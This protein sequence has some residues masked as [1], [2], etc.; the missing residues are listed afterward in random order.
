MSTVDIAALGTLRP[1]QPLDLT[2]YPAPTVKADKPKFVMAP[3]GVYELALPTTLTTDNFKVSQTGNLVFKFDATIVSGPFAGTNVRFQSASASV[4]TD[5]NGQER[6]MLGD[7]VAAAGGDTFPGVG[8]DGSPAPQVNA[9]T[10]LAGRTFKAYLNW[11]AVDR[12]FGS[13]IDV[14]GASKF[15]TGA[16]GQPQPYF[17]LNGQNG[18]PEIKNDRGYPQRVW[19]NLEISNYETSRS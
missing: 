14:K 13:G 19:A 12:K 16:D 11:H 3:P 15:P 2:K 10:A 18:L 1:S 17:E 4:F 8:E 6:S 7:L 9:I 5:K